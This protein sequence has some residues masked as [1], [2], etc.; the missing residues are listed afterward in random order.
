MSK[1]PLEFAHAGV[2]G[3]LEGRRVLVFLVLAALTRI[4]AISAFENGSNDVLVC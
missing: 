1:F 3:A 4:I 2:L